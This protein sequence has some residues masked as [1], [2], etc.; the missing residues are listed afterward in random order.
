MYAEVA[1]RFG[2]ERDAGELERAFPAAFAAVRARWRVAYGADDEDARRFWIEVIAGTFGDPMPY[3]IVCEL[4]DTF[5]TARRWRVLPGVREALAA[6]AAR[7]L[8]MA[9]VS[10]FDCRL[11]PLL[12]ELGL[13]PFAQIITSASVGAA[14]PDPA[15]LLAACRT[16]GVD[17]AATL[18]VGDSAREDG[19][20][21]ERAG[22][23]WFSIDPGAGIPLP[24]LLAILG[25]P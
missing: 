7:G 15:A 12:R 8:P 19:G 21:C 1:A 24:D 23:R 17:P 18:H 10:N 20:C 11:P 16:C 9:V 14:K 4:Y 25:A 13:G 6:V 2:L 22:A 5:A 3:E